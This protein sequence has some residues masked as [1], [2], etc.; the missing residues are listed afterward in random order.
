MNKL[1]V[2]KLTLAALFISAAIQ[3]VTGVSM[4]FGTLLANA[5]LLG[6]AIDIHKYNGLVFVLLVAAHIYQN[7]GW[8]KANIFKPRG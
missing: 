2:M 5:G 7:R 6:V 1:S 3:I 8:I 4:F